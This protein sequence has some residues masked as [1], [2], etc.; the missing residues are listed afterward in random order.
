MNNNEKL[1]FTFGILLGLLAAFLMFDGQIL[2]SDTTGIA[3]VLGIMA[4][5][6]IA[7]GPSLL[8]KDRNESEELP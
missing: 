6:F 7:S 2:G 5:G 4:I 3:R 1:S 8:G